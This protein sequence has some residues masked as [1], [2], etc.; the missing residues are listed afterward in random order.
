[1]DDRVD[2]ESESAVEVVGEA[3]RGV[4]LNDSIEIESESDDATASQGVSVDALDEDIEPEEMEAEPESPR[5]TSPWEESSPIQEREAKRRR[6][7]ISPLRESSPSDEDGSLL[8]PESMDETPLPAHIPNSDSLESMEDIRPGQDDG[9]ALQQPTFRAPPRFKPI[10]ADLSTEGLPAA[11]SPQR[12][13]AKYLPNG[14]AAELQGWLSE[15]KGW[16]GVDRTAEAS[17]TITVEEVR[18]GKRMYLVKAKVDAGEAKRFMLAGEGRLTG[19]GRRAVI[20]V[21]SRVCVGQ[22][23][24][25]VDLDGETWTVACDWSVA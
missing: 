16:E 2:D 14:L 11:F 9:R 15:V 20:G 25:D 8:D 13:G 22:P 7:T 19:L 17:L 18:S 24:W 6:V 3:R 12:R 1:M 4:P 21:G 5:S 23:V 10:E